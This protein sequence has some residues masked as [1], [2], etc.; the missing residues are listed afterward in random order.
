MLTR[1]S[2]SAAGQVFTL[3]S[4][5]SAGVRAPKRRGQFFTLYSVILTEGDGTTMRFDGDGKQDLAVANRNANTITVHFGL[6]NGS[7]EAPVVLVANVE[8]LGAVDMSN[9]P[10]GKDELVATTEYGGGV[11]D[12]S[13]L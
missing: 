1:F 5:T 4:F 7:F 3:Y 8:T 9:P 11:V 12:A 6:G 2:A 10:D 13:W